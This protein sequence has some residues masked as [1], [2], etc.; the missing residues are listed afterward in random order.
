MKDGDLHW[1]RGGGGGGRGNV[2]ILTFIVCESMSSVAAYCDEQHG[3]QVDGLYPG[4]LFW[5]N[6]S[7][8][9]E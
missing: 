1:H 5:R 8:C 4:F 9:F 2:C 3:L 7:W 6:Y